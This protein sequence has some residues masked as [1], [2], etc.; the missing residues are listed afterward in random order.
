MDNNNVENI[1]WLRREVN[2]RLE[3][4]FVQK[5]NSN[6]QASP[7][8]TNYRIFK[9]NFKIK[10]YITELQPHSFVTLS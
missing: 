7:K 3:M 6:V 10:P 2:S 8:C 1:N 4:Q 5:W 9:P